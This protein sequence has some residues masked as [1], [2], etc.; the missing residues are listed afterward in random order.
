MR[1]GWNDKNDIFVGFKAGS[2]YVNHGHMDVGSFIIDAK[3]ER[4]ASDFGSQDYN[5]LESAGV[6]LWN[7]SQNSE[8]WTVFRYNNRA[9]N[10]LTVN[11]KLQI[12]GGTAQIDSH[13]EGPGMLNAISNISAV[14]AGQLSKTV[15]GIA[16]VDDAYVMIRDEVETSS[17]STLIRWNLLTSAAVTL[18]GPNTAELTKNGKKMTLKVVQPA[19]VTMKT[20]STVSPNSYDAANPGTIFTGFEVT[21]PAS[22]KTSLVVLLLPDGAEENTSVTA[23]KLSEWPVN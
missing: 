2:P 6:D 9:H 18:T 3:G 4:W 12:V 7:R 22:S 10:T 23:K 1:S 19:S 20:W 15:R 5:S 21:L 11:D 17:S 14:Y 8:R 13:Y 16:I